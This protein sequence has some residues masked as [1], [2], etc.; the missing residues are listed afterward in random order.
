VKYI[1][2]LDEGKIDGK[3]SKLVRDKSIWRLEAKASRVYEWNNG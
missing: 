1:G 2:S 3:E